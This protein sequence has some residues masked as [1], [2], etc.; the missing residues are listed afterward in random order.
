MGP[1]QDLLDGK[2]MPIVQASAR[3]LA[4]IEDLPARYLSTIEAVLRDDRRHSRDG[5]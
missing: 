2:A 3:Y 5:G 1:V 4:E